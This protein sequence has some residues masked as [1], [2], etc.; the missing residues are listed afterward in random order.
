VE[1]KHRVLVVDDEEMICE[2]LASELESEGYSAS[3]ATSGRE[4]LERV[5]A[6]R[7]DIALIDLIM[8]DM[9]GLAVMN[10]IGKTSPDTVCIV[11]TGHAPQESAI[12]ASDL[13]AYGYLLKPIDM[14]L[15]LLTMRKALEYAALRRSLRQAEQTA[16]IL[17]EQ[18]ESATVVVDARGTVLS[19]NDPAASLLESG[20][21]DIIGTSLYDHPAGARL[22]LDAER[23]AEAAEAGTGRPLKA[24]DSEGSCNVDVAAVRDAR[25]EIVRCVIRLGER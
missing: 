16:A 2:F 18:A 21:K 7:P 13:G 24:A 12:A 22:G 15:L 17:V 5:E 10:T 6:E 9:P 8:E 3:S 20:K 25:N 19:L 14:D 11:I 4:A 23:V 1:K